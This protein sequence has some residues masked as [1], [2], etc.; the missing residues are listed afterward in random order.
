MPRHRQQAAV[1][2]ESVDVNA[3]ATHADAEEER[4]GAEEAQ[5]DGILE[6]LPAVLGFVERACRRAEADEEACFALKLATEEAFVNIVDHGGPQAGRPV[7]LRFREDGGRG[8]LTI[9]DHG[10]S[11]SPD[12]ARVPDL[13]A[14]WRQRPVGGLGLHLVRSMVD[15]LDYRSDRRGANTLTLVKALRQEPAS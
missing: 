8:I 13:A 9:T 14:D 11:F 15:D 4:L 12:E 7:R 10:R 2:S 5:F 1:S 3:Q 6:S